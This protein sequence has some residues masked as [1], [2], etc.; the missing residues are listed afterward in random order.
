[1]SA[2]HDRLE[3]ANVIY[4]I[5]TDADGDSVSFLPKI[6]SNT[7]WEAEELEEEINKIL[8]SKCHQ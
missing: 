1:L 3:H 7:D 6:G 5:P 8:K 2:L 4:E